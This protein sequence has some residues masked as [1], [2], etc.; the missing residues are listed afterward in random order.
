MESLY[1]PNMLDY[2]PLF[3]TDHQYGEHGRFCAGQLNHGMSPP[4]P[5]IPKPVGLGFRV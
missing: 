5:S 4:K 1:I 3:L 2:V